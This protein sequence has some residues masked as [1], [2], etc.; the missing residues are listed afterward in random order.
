MACEYT[1]AQSEMRA[2]IIVQSIC[3]ATAVDLWPRQWFYPPNTDK[4]TD[5][6][7]SNYFPTILRLIK[8]I[9]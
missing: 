8:T 1:L 6:G 9:A 3:N 5:V 4:V 7:D 2:A